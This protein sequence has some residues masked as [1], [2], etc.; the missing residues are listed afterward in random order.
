MN[1]YLISS[2]VRK[3]LDIVWH[4]KRNLG[5]KLFAKSRQQQTLKA[6]ACFLLYIYAFIPLKL[7]AKDLNAHT[8]EK[9][10]L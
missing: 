4:L 3:E 1:N 7:D 2:M 5:H 6:I 8:K 9:V 10:G